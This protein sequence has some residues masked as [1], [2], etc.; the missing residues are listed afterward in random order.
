MLKIFISVCMI[1]GLAWSQSLQDPD[2]ISL[3]DA[4][5]RFSEMAKEQN[6]RDAFLEFL[7]D[8]AVTFGKDARI[9]KKHLDLQKSEDS[10]LSW[11]PTYTDLAASRDFG[12]NTGPWELRENRSAP[13]PVAYGHFATVWEK[14]NG[15]WKARIDIGIS[16]PRPQE[17]DSLMTSN[18]SLRNVQAVSKSIMQKVIAEEQKFIMDFARNSN[19][20]YAH[21]LSED[22]RIYRHQHLPV[23]GKVVP[24]NVK[25]VSYRFM[26]GDIASSGD[27]AY[28]YGKALIELREKGVLTSI[29]ANYMR[30][31]KKE[32]G[33]N[34][35]I[36]V[37]V[38]TYL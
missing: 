32:D 24:E 16:H 34:W 14:E 7:S 35:K 4:E 9:G 11:V 12:F 1:P 20:A 17:T 21:V 33:K 30:I 22:S 6:T 2:L 13:E 15:I 37:D 29:D 8:S 10:W 3:I 23:K 27:L 19:A 26:D 36:V 28:V 18:V 25:A 38:L 5:R 31:W